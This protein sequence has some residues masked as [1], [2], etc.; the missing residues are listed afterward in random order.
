MLFAQPIAL[1]GLALAA[2]ATTAK[3]LAVRTKHPSCNSGSLKCCKHTYNPKTDPSVGSMLGLLG[4]VGPL[5]EGIVS[6]DC[7]TVSVIG[8]AGQSCSMQTVCCSHDTF[9]SGLFSFG[10]TPINIVL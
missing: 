1:L 5:L 4:F 3:P 7:T 2:L 10:C 9:Q 6:A 8:A